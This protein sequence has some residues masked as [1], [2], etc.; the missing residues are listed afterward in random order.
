MDE[1]PSLEAEE[2]WERVLWKKQNNLPD[3]YIG[4]DFFRVTKK[5]LVVSVWQC[6]QGCLPITRFVLMNNIRKDKVKNFILIL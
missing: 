5:R 3:N 2:K 4:R 1:E 6:L